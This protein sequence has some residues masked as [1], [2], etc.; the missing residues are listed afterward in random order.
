MGYSDT[1]VVVTGMGI[2]TPI[3][4]D[5]RSYEQAL[6]AGVSGISPISQ[7]DCQTVDPRSG[8]PQFSTRIAGE[9][10]GFRPE[11]FLPKASRYDR[12]SQF[13]LCAAR[14]ALEDAGLDIASVTPQRAGVVMGTGM[15]DMRMIEAGMA[16]LVAKGANHIGPT[17][18]VKTLPS[19]LPG[20]V[21]IFF[22]FRGPCLGVSSAC[23]SATHA[24]GEAAFMLRRGEADMILAGGAEASI[25]PLT[26]ASFSAMR[27]MS[28][29]NDSP[30]AASRPF[31]SL[32]D[33]FVM[34]EGSG[35]LVLETLDRARAR[36]ARIYAEIAGYGLT[37]DAFH[38]SS[39]RPDSTECARAI[40]LAMERARISPDQ[41]DY[42]S[43]HGTST[44][45]ND[46]VE[47][48]AIKE[49]LGIHAKRPLVSATKS[50]IGHLL[51]AAGAAEL[52]AAILAIASQAVHPTV[53][54][55]CPDPDCD[56]NHVRGGAARE[57][58]VDVVLK[59]SFGFG[60]QN[61]A[62]ILKRWRG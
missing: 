43:A 25:T 34:G 7:F 35:M 14:M 61:A 26:V 56:L 47:A 55:E 4:K 52:V 2:I 41:I 37:S 22:G 13:A 49:A 60:G 19:L 45:M 29:R 48:Q 1:R 8:E 10:C 58:A 42:V 5:L 12:A 32:R 38:A 46:L 17:A 36:G 62:I 40:R 28:S 3:G 53:N 23:A 11:E 59:N 44:R 33:G 51:S 24:V 6:C 27:I 20:N 18:I 30:T 9:V 31:D 15:G 50:M 54:L 57:S 39:M 21:S 16:T